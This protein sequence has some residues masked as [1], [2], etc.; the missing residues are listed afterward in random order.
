M[1]SVLFNRLLVVILI[2]AGTIVLIPGINALENSCIDCHKTLTPFIEEQKRF[3]SNKD[4]A[5]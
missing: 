3:K 4:T 2:L 5:P 1:R